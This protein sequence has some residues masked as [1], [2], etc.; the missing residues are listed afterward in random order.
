MR[1]LWIHFND[2]W[3]WV[4]GSN[5]QVCSFQHQLKERVMSL[6]MCLVLRTRA[7]CRKELELVIWHFKFLLG[8]SHQ[9]RDV[10]TFWH[11][12]GMISDYSQRGLYGLESWGADCSLR[13]FWLHPLT[14]SS[15]LLS[16]GSQ[17]LLKRRHCRKRQTTLALKNQSIMLVLNGRHPAEEIVEALFQKK[18]IKRRK[19]WWKFTKIL[20]LLKKVKWYTKLSHY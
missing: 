2:I 17:Y 10:I 9:A 4:H 15:H 13:L 12:S 18:K 11:A 1:N 5:F 6:R 3:V 16:E 8:L 20:G 19:H 14:G 7:T